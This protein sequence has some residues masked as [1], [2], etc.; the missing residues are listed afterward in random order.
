MSDRPTC[1]RRE[2]TVASALAL[3]NGVTIS[4]NACGDS[5][6]TT[7]STPSSPTTPAPSGAPAPSP[8]GGVS[9]VVGTNHGHTATI[10][11]AELASGEALMIDIEGEAGHPHSVEL[12][13]DEVRRIASGERVAKRASVLMEDPLYPEVGTHTHNVTFN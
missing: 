3:L 5:A 4:L 13:A 1:S 10:T 9:G 12:T 7:S 8:S 6:G 2:F 11:A